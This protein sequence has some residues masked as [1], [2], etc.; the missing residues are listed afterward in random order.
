MAIHW[1]TSQFEMFVIGIERRPKIRAVGERRARTVRCLL[2]RSAR[3]EK[4]IAPRPDAA[5]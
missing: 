2:A 3:E 5:S 1:V 4:P